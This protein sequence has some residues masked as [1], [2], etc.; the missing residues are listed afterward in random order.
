VAFSGLLFAIS[1]TF[2]QNAWM[3]AKTPPTD[4]NTAIRQQVVKQR[5]AKKDKLARALRDNLRRRKFAATDSEN[6]GKEKGE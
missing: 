3:E 1:I 6:G 5:Q 4:C 2:G